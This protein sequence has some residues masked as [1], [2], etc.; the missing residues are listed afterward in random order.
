MSS[1]LRDMLHFAIAS[2]AFFLYGYLEVS[3]QNGYLVSIALAAYFILR[4]TISR[5][6]SWMTLAFHLTSRYVWESPPLALMSFLVLDVMFLFQTFSKA[7]VNNS[8]QHHK[9]TAT[10]TNKSTSPAK[11]KDITV[12]PRSSP[13]QKKALPK[14]SS[15][16]HDSSHGPINQERSA[17]TTNYFT[18]PFVMDNTMQQS[19]PPTPPSTPFQEFFPTNRGYDGLKSFPTSKPMSAEFVTISLEEFTHGSVLA[20][21]GSNDTVVVGSTT[22][23]GRGPSGTSTPKQHTPKAKKIQ[24]R[25]IIMR[26]LEEAREEEFKREQELLHKLQDHAEVA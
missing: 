5:W 8:Q 23:E 2:T 15:T 19:T 16:S 12:T 13:Q 20:G 4:G 25:E 6:L 18:Q 14:L 7:L 24:D 3:Q 26:A 21:S 1:S 10:S 9:L 17:M 11:E 22:L